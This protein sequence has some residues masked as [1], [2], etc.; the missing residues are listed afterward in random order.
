MTARVSQSEERPEKT[1]STEPQ[2][3]NNAATRDTSSI[4]RR[5]S[6]TH[7]GARENVL[8]A[9]SGAL[10]LDARAQTAMLSNAFAP[11]QGAVQEPICGKIN[12]ELGELPAVL[13]ALQTEGAQGQT[14]LALVLR[15]MGAN[16]DIGCT[17][18]DLEGELVPENFSKNAHDVLLVCRQLKALG[19]TMGHFIE[20]FEEITRVLKSPAPSV[21]TI[22]SARESD[23][24]L[25]GLERTVSEVMSIIEEA[26]DFG[27]NSVKDLEQL[28]AA[29]Q[30]LPNET[31][32]GHLIKVVNDVDPVRFGVILGQYR[33]LLKVMEELKSATDLSSA[34]TEALVLASNIA[35]IAAK[36]EYAQLSPAQAFTEAVRKNKN[37][38]ALISVVENTTGALSILGFDRSFPA[39]GLDAVVLAAIVAKR[40]PSSYR[41]YFKWCSSGGA[42]AFYRAYQ[43]WSELVSVEAEWL[44]RLSGYAPH[45]R[46][47]PE[48]LESAVTH[49]ACVGFQRIRLEFAGLGMAARKL[50]ARVGFDPQSA[51]I[52]ED[53]EALTVHLRAVRRF[54][55]NVTYQHMF[56]SEW[57]GLDTRFDKIAAAIWIIQNVK[58]YFNTVA[59]GKRVFD[60]LVL[61]EAEQLEALG[62]LASSMDGLRTLSSDLRSKIEQCTIEALVSELEV[63]QRLA[64]KILDVDPERIAATISAPLSKVHDTAAR[65]ILRRELMESIEG[66]SFAPAVKKFSDS[67]E[68]A[69][70]ALKG[71]TW[72][73]IVRRKELTPELRSQLLSKDAI[74]ARERLRDLS[75]RARTVLRDLDDHVTK[76]E[77]QLGIN[78]LSTLSPTE[79]LAQL[80]AHVARRDELVAAR[81]N[82]QNNSGRTIRLRVT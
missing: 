28:I 2:R 22:R 48:E 19:E 45:C 80:N 59:H 34:S 29:D 23:D 72:V 32:P 6:V 21:T 75:D 49:V 54:C 12:E 51:Q 40:L 24:R 62:S 68:T 52:R 77:E 16:V 46:P 30:D 25:H 66:D 82:G 55:T 70:A 41:D 8:T 53:L 61:L 58:R 71:V 9:Q 26:R 11:H 14:P 57:A 10:S 76:V 27:V 60:R 64:E 78:G 56:G 81:G 50:I 63:E 13:F 15:A 36:S 67:N 79:L 42:D 37:A 33:R 31:P 44:E 4:V 69:E 73:S 3:S 35:S 20:R 5:S 43:K 1:A 7:L 74:R 65:E 39:S 18:G 47:S 17:S 38:R